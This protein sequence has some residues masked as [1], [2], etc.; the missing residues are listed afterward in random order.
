MTD[1]YITIRQLFEGTLY[2]S[3]QLPWYYLFKYIS[4]T[5]PVAVI[6]GVVLSIMYF[7]T[8]L[9]RKSTS[10]YLSILLFFTLFPLIFILIKSSNVYGAWRH[11]LFI[12]PPLVIISA[13]GYKWLTD[14]LKNRISKY[15]VAVVALLLLFEPALFMVR[16]HPYEVVY[17]NPLIGG[18]KGAQGNYEMDYYYHSTREAAEKLKEHIQLHNEDSII[19]AGNFETE[20]FFRNYT[21]VTDNIYTP[22]YYKNNKNWDYNIITAAYM[23]PL[24]LQP[25][26]WP[27]SNTIFTIDVN[28][29][30]ICAVLKRQTKDDW[31][32]IELIKE[33]QIDSAVVLLQNVIRNYPENETAYLELGKIY[34]KTARYL[35]AERTFK[36]CLNVLP[37][38]EPAY[39]YLAET[40]FK[41]GDKKVAIQTLKKILSI[42]SKYLLAYINLADY[43]KDLD[44]DKEA[45]NILNE[46]LKIKPKYNKAINKLEELKK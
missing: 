27:P 10:L 39:Y 32:A 25:G 2:W 26:K 43:Y 23:T 15:L 5:I 20:W 29:V 22:Y 19:V 16:N 17:F 38:Y 45:I 34:L 35:L 28:H 14:K 40:Q 24:S 33:G 46:C 36:Q 37:S 11:V 41:A 3:D 42:N 44:Q 4:I 7:R 12:Y 30:P 31:K 9:F 1:Y 21:K 8:N 13:L 6:A 18:I